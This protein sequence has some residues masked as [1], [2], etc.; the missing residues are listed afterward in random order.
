M[1]TCGDIWVNVQWRQRQNFSEPEHRQGT[2]I[3]TG[4]PL[5]LCVPFLFLIEASTYTVRTNGI[6]HIVGK[7][8]FL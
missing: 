3:Y 6:V 4:V 7:I 1:T 5:K 2:R 8:F